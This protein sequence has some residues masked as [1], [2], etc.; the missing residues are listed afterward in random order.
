MAESALALLTNGELHARVASQ[1]RKSV[2]KRF[3]R[4]LIV[5]QYEAFYTATLGR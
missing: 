1:S 3:C 4:D 5:P 2:R